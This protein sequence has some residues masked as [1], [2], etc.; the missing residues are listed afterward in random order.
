MTAEDPILTT[1]A[2]LAA[3]GE[4]VTPL[5]YERFVQRLPAAEGLMAHMD[6]H[7]LGRMMSDLLMLVMTP[8]EEIDQ[9][10]LGFEISSHDAYGVGPEMFTP[11]FEAVRDAVRDAAG[12]DWSEAVDA[13]WTI[14]LDGIRA[15]IEAVRAPA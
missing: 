15:A 5:L 12:R 8:P 11:L 10:Y 2:Y 9:D 14:R 3:S 4:D 7:M 1:M 13:A 6:E